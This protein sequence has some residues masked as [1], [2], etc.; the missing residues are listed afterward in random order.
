[1]P[2]IA[3]QRALKFWKIRIKSEAEQ[4]A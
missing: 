3:A 1:V 2:A 4:A